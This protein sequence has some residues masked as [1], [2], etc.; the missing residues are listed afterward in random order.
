MNGKIDSKLSN[1]GNLPVTVKTGN[2]VKISLCNYDDDDDEEDEEEKELTKSTLKNLKPATSTSE[3]SGVKRPTS[4]L[5]SILPPPK[6]NKFI[7][8]KKAEAPSTSMPSF[9][10][11]RTLK[12]PISLAPLPVNDHNDEDDDDDDEESEIMKRAKRLRQDPPLNVVLNLNHGNEEDDEEENDPD[13]D[14]EPEFRDDD[15]SEQSSKISKGATYSNKGKLEL[16]SDALQKLCGG[17]KKRHDVPFEITDVKANDIVGDNRSELMKQITNEYKPSSN[18]DY[19]S[20]GGRKKHQ[21]TYLAYVAKERDQELRNT[22]AQ[23]KFNKQQARQKY[24]F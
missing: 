16:D 12:Q 22:W 14:P 10:I 5:L 3:S 8:E 9:L 20:G 4:G 13:D 18:R 17:N 6:S 2:K 19:F 23:G 11:P 15:E 7:S 24:G 1:T 21:I